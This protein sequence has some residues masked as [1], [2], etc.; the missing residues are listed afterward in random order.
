MAWNSFKTLGQG[1]APEFKAA[2]PVV[3]GEH[4]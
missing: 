2:E 1:K 3:W 4:A